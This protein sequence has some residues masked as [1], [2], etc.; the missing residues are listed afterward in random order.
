VLSLIGLHGALDGTQLVLDGRVL[1]G[2]ADTGDEGKACLEE[3]DDLGKWCQCLDMP[4][5]PLPWLGL[6]MRV[7]VVNRDGLWRFYSFF[8]TTST[9]IRNGQVDKQ[10]HDLFLQQTWAIEF[11]SGGG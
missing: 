9:W 10:K 5:I 7:N 8:V 1:I 3:P 2:M 11:R 6:C 4:V